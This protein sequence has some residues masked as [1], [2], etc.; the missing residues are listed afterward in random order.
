M[1]GCVIEWVVKWTVNSLRCFR[2]KS[3]SHT[4]NRGRLLQI[5]RACDG[6]SQL[7][8]RAYLCANSGNEADGLQPSAAPRRQRTPDWT[9]QMSSPKIQRASGLFPNRKTVSALSNLACSFR[10]KNKAQVYTNNALKLSRATKKVRIAKFQIPRLYNLAYDVYLSS[11]DFSKHRCLK[12]LK[13][14]SMQ[15]SDRLTKDSYRIE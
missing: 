15:S 2:I 12:K 3:K 14:F 5:P 8:N 7:W 10:R 13:W 6:I 4:R 11:S 9:S 1:T